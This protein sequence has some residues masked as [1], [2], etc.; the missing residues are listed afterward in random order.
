MKN[1]LEL[2][3]KLVLLAKPKRS[4]VNKSVATLYIYFSLHGNQG[5]QTLAE[6]GEE[7]GATIRRMQ[8]HLLFLLFPSPSPANRIRSIDISIGFDD[9]ARMNIQ[10]LGIGAS[11]IEGGA[12]L[13]FD[14]QY[15]NIIHRHAPSVPFFPSRRGPP[16]DPV[17]II[18][19]LTR[20]V[21]RRPNPHDPPAIRDLSIYPPATTFS[22]RNSRIN[23]LCARDPS[24]SSCARWSSSPNFRAKLERKEKERNF[25]KKI[26]AIK[27]GGGKGKYY[28]SSFQFLFRRWTIDC[29]SMCS[30]IALHRLPSIRGPIFGGY[31]YIGGGDK[32]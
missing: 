2:R 19:H 8:L 27:I 1:Y 9:E 24:I 23:P 14:A 20:D 31:I 16:G 28:S 5:T 26:C 15:A 18:P 17:R 13:P 4:F 3:N 6:G 22:R 10:G 30:N 7:T 21:V 32:C 25:G 12:R 11:C 29:S